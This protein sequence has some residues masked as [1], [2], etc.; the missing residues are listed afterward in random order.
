MRPPSPLH[1]QGSFDDRGDPCTVGE[2]EGHPDGVQ[3]T[4]EQH[5]HVPGKVHLERCAVLCHDSMMSWSKNGMFIWYDTVSIV[6]VVVYMIYNPPSQNG[7]SNIMGR[8]NSHLWLVSKQQSSSW[9]PCG[10]SSWHKRN[11]KTYGTCNGCNGFV[12]EQNKVW[13]D[14]ALS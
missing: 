5:A 11:Q 8:L 2:E 4:K 14:D 1:L 12:W 7:Q 9:H 6:M 13:Y 3:L 10:L